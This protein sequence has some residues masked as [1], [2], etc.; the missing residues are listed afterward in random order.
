MRW[1]SGRPFYLP[2]HWFIE[3][4]LTY[5]EAAQLWEVE[6]FMRAQKNTYLFTLQESFSKKRQNLKVSPRRWRQ[7]RNCS[8]SNEEE[9]FCHFCCIQ[10]IFCYLCFR[11]YF[12]T[13]VVFRI[14]FVTCI[15]FRIYFVTCI[16]FRIYFLFNFST[17]TFIGGRRRVFLFWGRIL[18]LLYDN[19][20]TIMMIIS[21]LIIM[22]II[23]W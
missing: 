14:Y 23:D 20:I 10:N 12:V 6:L 3:S 13:C 19:D 18:D 4:L 17:L 7:T 16:V 15:V 11:I 5:E 22:I 21:S 9:H 2:D 8:T 1:R